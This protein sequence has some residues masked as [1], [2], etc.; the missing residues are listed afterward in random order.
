MWLII[1]ISKIIIIAALA[2]VIWS[3]CNRLILL[4]LRSLNILDL[5]S[6]STISVYGRGRSTLTL[7]IYRFFSTCDFISHIRGYCSQPIADK[8]SNS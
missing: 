1:L 6:Q 5:L 7:L 2:H 3:D 8:L 4:L